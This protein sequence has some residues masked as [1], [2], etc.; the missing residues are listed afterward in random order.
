MPKY[1][2]K[3]VIVEAERVNIKEGDIAWNHG[4]RPGDWIITDSDGNRWFVTN[5]EF[6]ATY[7]R[8]E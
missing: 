5:E 2:K 6:E 8:V 4:V 3:P 7:E 1:R